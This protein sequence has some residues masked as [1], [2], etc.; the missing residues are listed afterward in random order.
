MQQ[1]PLRILGGVGSTLVI[2]FTILWTEIFFLKCKGDWPKKDGRVEDTQPINTGF[3]LKNMKSYGCSELFWICLAIFVYEVE[4]LVDPH[5]LLIFFCIIWIEALII[6]CQYNSWKLVP[7]TECNALDFFF[8]T[9]T[10]YI[11]SLF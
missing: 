5:L 10:K 11:I 7:R 6:F 9:K 4:E 2:L 8:L 3:R 1:R